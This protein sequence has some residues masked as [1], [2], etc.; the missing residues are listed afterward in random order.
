MRGWRRVVFRRDAAGVRPVSSS[1]SSGGTRRATPLGS[2]SPAASSASSAA[3]AV[4]ARPKL[5]RGSNSRHSFDVASAFGAASSRFGWNVASRMGVREGRPARSVVL[6][7]IPG[8]VVASSAARRPDAGLAA[9]RRALRAASLSPVLGRDEGVP[10]GW[11]GDSFSFEIPPAGEVPPCDAPPPPPPDDEDARFCLKRSS[12]DAG[13][14]VPSSPTM[15]ARAAPRVGLWAPP[16]VAVDFLEKSS[17]SRRLEPTNA[18]NADAGHRH[19]HHGRGWQDRAVD[20]RV[21]R[22]GRYVPSSSSHRPPSVPSRPAF[23]PFAGPDPSAPQILAHQPTQTLLPLHP[24]TQRY[25]RTR[26]RA[27]PPRRARS[28]ASA[29]SWASTACP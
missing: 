18:A 19:G 28:D 1:F 15:S 29:Y 24:S 21:H 13:R 11:R 23:W 4:R 8:A 9:E 10:R 7:S 22:V 26:R 2:V 3:A 25:R 14:R 20:R 5:P 12:D 6:G 16:T 27:A 17:I